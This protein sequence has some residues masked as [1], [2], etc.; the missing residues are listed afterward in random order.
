MSF[1]F[2]CNQSSRSPDGAS[3][4]VDCGYALSQEC[5]HGCGKHD[6]PLEEE[7]IAPAR[8]SRCHRFLRFCPNCRRLHRLS[9]A[10]C[11]TSRC[12]GQ[13]TRETFAPCIGTKADDT[14]RAHVPVPAPY[15]RGSDL[16][17]PGVFPL[18]PGLGGI[19]FR[20]GL[21]SV[22]TDGVLHLL[23]FHVHQSRPLDGNDALVTI[24]DGTPLSTHGEVLPHEDALNLAHG[25]AYLLT[26]VGALRV[27]LVER[28]AQ[29]LIEAKSNWA[30]P[31]TWEE[32]HGSSSSSS[33]GAST[34]M[35]D[36]S[37]VHWQRQSTT[38]HH[39]V[40]VGTER[41]ELCVVACEADAPHFEASRLPVPD[42]LRASHPVDV[43][44]WDNDFLFVFPREVWRLHFGDDTSGVVIQSQGDSPFDSPFDAAD[45]TPF[46]AVWEQ[47]W[48]TP[49]GFAPLG[50]LTGPDGEVLLWGQSGV[51]TE[52]HSLSI[53]SDGRAQSTQERQLFRCRDVYHRPV[54]LGNQLCLFEHDSEGH[55]IVA[56]NL[57]RPLDVPVRATFVGDSRVI[58]AMGTTYGSTHWIVYALD[59]GKDISLE[60]RPLDV[61]DGTVAHSWGISWPIGRKW[62]VQRR[63][64]TGASFSATIADGL[65]CVA[66]VTD[67]G[68][69]MEAFDLANRYF[70][71]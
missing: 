31:L 48:C 52:V 2:N 68:A 58:W 46:G 71:Q 43:L 28:T 70:N 5:P 53:G 30:A 49:A 65:L 10:I 12:R 38:L 50:V 42:A 14:N 59:D 19:A 62:R 36:F 26:E 69:Q 13:A 27:P 35:P 9:E 37:D 15:Q 45:A 66:S 44:A 11:H 64:Q 29:P 34:T 24:F 54:L 55:A 21:V 61:A 33:L 18:P 47:F 39:W 17:F 8:C 6:I 22:M 7:G 51:E 67:E 16:A 20:Y 60:A 40:G 57:R 23:P 3:Y 56:A 32:S 4:C 1:C 41:G 63:K 25:H